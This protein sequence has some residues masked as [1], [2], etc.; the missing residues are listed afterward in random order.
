MCRKELVTSASW[1][2]QLQHSAIV[3]KEF[4]VA[5]HCFAGRT[6]LRVLPVGLDWYNLLFE[7]A[8]VTSLSSSLV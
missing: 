7:P 3:A 8:S 5:P 6:C 1:V 2:H 4:G